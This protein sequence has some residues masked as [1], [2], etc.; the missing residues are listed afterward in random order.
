M[1]W[2]LL[3]TAVVLLFNFGFLLGAYWAGERR[4]RRFLDSLTD[5]NLLDLIN[6]SR[7]FL[8][9]AEMRALLTRFFLEGGD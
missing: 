5:S 2:I 3:T 1:K 4:E 7:T 9:P 8:D 6:D